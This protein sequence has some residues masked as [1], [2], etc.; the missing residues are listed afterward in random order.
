MTHQG[1]SGRGTSGDKAHVKWRQEAF[2]QFMMDG[3]EKRVGLTVEYVRGEVVELLNRTQPLASGKD[4][5]RRG[6][7]PSKPGKPPKRVEG[8]LIQSIAA[9]VVRTRRKI[10]GFVGT[11]VVYARRLELGFF[12]LDSLGRL[13]QQAA[14]PFL[15]PAVIDNKETIRRLL[16]GAGI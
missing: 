16:T 2:V 3:F 11:N 12:D 5:R 14:R 10:R 7:N 15:R 9:K 1:S 8:R 4:G 6:L 13:I